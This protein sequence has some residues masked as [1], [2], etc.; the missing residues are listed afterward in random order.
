MKVI[1]RHKNWVLGAT[2]A[3]LDDENY[4]GRFA[5]RKYV[6]TIRGFRG[7]KI[8]EGEIKKCMVDI[9]KSEVEKIRNKIDNGD[10]EIF[11]DKRYK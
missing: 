9:V 11:K 2:I 1:A 8:Y 5:Y 6:A 4:N 7:W 3:E 10:E